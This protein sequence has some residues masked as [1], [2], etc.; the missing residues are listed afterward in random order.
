MKRYL[1]LSILLLPLF[2]IR[3]KAD[4]IKWVDFD[5]PYESMN[6]AMNVDIQTFDQEKHIDWID[7]LAVAACRTGGKCGLDSVRKAAADL[8]GDRSAQELLSG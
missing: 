6:Y 2:S 3:A 1:I 5:I 4:I 7:I 8:K